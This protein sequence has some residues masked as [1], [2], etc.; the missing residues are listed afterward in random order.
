MTQ[1]HFGEIQLTRKSPFSLP[2]IAS[3]I[4]AV[5]STIAGIDDAGDG[6]DTQ[7]NAEANCQEGGDQEQGN[8]ENVKK[9][10]KGNEM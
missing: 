4:P 5:V 8:A 9:T 1:Q 7:W 10:Q 2:A 3:R 6:K